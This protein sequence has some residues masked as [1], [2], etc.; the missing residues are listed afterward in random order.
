MQLRLAC[1]AVVGLALSGAAYCQ[2]VKNLYVY[3][4]VSEPELISGRKISTV[5]D[6]YC[7]PSTLGITTYDRNTFRIP[8]NRVE[9]LRNL[10]SLTF[11]VEDTGKVETTYVTGV[12]VGGAPFIEDRDDSPGPRPVEINEVG[13]KY[14]GVG[15]IDGGTATSFRPAFFTG[16]RLGFDKNSP[17]TVY[18]RRARFPENMPFASSLEIRLSTRDGCRADSRLELMID[19]YDGQ[20]LHVPVGSMGDNARKTIN[21]SLKMPIPLQGIKKVYVWFNNRQFDNNLLLRNTDSLAQP[22]DVDLTV[23]IT[24]RG[25]GQTVNFVSDRR[26]Q[27]K[28][29]KNGEITVTESYARA[30]ADDFLSELTLFT[31]T[32]EKSLDWSGRNG[33]K[34]R[35]AASIRDVN[36][37]EYSMTNHSIEPDSNG[38]LVGGAFT[39]KSWA[40]L[41]SNSRAVPR[42][43][44]LSQLA[45]VTISTIPV[46]YPR[47]GE[48]IVQTWDM[49]GLAI[50]MKKKGDPDDIFAQQSI[51]AD[52]TTNELFTFNFN[53]SAAH[54]SN[55]RMYPFRAN[56]ITYELHYR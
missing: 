52:L 37:R 51:F 41:V 29:W 54:G 8:L 5:V 43:F 18:W 1:A 36:G 49:A 35:L 21:K 53:V 17:L 23:N 40:R 48:S 9:D 55:V 38:T 15:S 44:R 14:F 33:P 11:R 34:M 30:Y 45:S 27:L 47:T 31:Q 6:W 10:K 7:G 16:T 28:D 22:D 39:S 19:T 56:Q 24:G 3:L 2:K 26:V 25:N 13:T 32:G 46:P 4:Q 42:G 50:G 20:F 12:T